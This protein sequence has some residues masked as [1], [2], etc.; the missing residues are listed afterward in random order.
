[1]DSTDYGFVID[2]NYYM[3]RCPSCQRENYTMAVASGICCWCGEDGRSDYQAKMDERRDAEDNPRLDKAVVKFNG[4]QG[5]ILC[6][7]CKVILYS[8]LTGPQWQQ[9]HST[10]GLPPKY[11]A[12]CTARQEL[13]ASLSQ[14]DHEQ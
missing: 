3:V 10:K 12:T 4:G 2:D 5:A 14:N 7:T 6:S 1:M 8:P 9:I 11:C 13:A